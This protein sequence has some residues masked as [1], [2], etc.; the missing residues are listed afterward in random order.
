MIVTAKVQLY[1]TA[2]QAG[3]MLFAGRAFAKACNHVSDVAFDTRNLNQVKLQRVVYAALRSDYSMPSQM[4]CNVVR[5]V[6]GSYKTI[7]A[8]QNKWIKPNFLHTTYA[9]SWNRDYS[10]TGNCFSVG[11]LCGRIKMNYASKGMERYFDGSWEFGVAKVVCKHGKWFLHISVSKDIAE[12]QDANVANISGVDLGINFL[13]AAYDSKG[14]TTFFDGKQIKHKRGHY[15][16]IRQQLQKRK[17]ASARSR[18]RKIGARENRWMQDIN[19]SV[20]KALVDASPNRTAFVLED[21]TGIRNATEKVRIKDRYVSVS[22]AFYDLR[23]KLEYKAQLTG[24]K[25]ILVSPKHTSQTCP[26]CG[27]VEKSNRNKRTHTFL[28]KN[29]RY[30]SNDDRVGAMNLHRKGI[31]YLSAVAVE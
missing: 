31:E 30:A 18:L 28:C 3:L 2:E 24:S 21:L 20:S 23:K 12:L 29:C 8:N 13:A 25:V 6:I 27:H 1:P 15:K 10:L 7:L 19:H 4:A 26:K 16:R 11:T 17:T 14:K 5:H 9:L 22:W